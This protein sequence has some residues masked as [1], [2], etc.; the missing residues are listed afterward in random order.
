VL[1][2]RPWS[3]PSAPASVRIFPPSR[4]SHPDPHQRTQRNGRPAAE[5]EAGPRPSAC[6]AL[7]VNQLALTL[8]VL[9]VAGFDWR[10]KLLKAAEPRHRHRGRRGGV[11][12][13]GSGIPP[14]FEEGGQGSTMKSSGRRAQP[15]RDARRRRSAGWLSYL[16]RLQEQ[17]G[18]RQN[19]FAIGGPARWPKATASARLAL[20]NRSATPGSFPPCASRSAAAGSFDAHGE[21]ADGP[22]PNA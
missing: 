4:S 3:P 10:R 21:T 9:V 16:G 15:A 19:S 2:F 7:V 1:N 14:P 8:V 22:G 18:E 20:K 6:A 13:S 12:T 11:L 5:P 17:H